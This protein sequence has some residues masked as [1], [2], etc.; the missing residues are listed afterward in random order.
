MRTA[1]GHQEAGPLGPY[2]EPRFGPFRLEEQG[3][4]WYNS[5]CCAE[6][7]RGMTM[8][9]CLD[10][11][12]SRDLGLQAVDRDAAWPGACRGPNAKGM[13]PSF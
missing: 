12:T 4:I 6:G 3:G 7:I 10:E 1:P 2:R 5:A 8:K 9:F 13:R 11:P